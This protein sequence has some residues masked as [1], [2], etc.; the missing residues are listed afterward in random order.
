[1]DRPLG[2]AD[3]ETIDWL[4]LNGGVIDEFRNNGGECGGRF[5][6]NPMILLTTIGAK[7]GL[8]RTS[9]LTY[10]MDGDRIVVIASRA[11]SDRHPDWYINLVAHRDVT[12][13]LGDESFAA[14][15]SIADEPERTRL[16]D[17]RI[18]VMPRFG[19]YLQAT[20]RVIPVVVLER[21]DG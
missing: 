2:N 11:G 14:V 4:G 15:A 10:T 1:M 12:V 21:A 19:E 3:P 7:S 5:E 13:E 9:P 18:A 6:G 16:F 8:E 20:N 17:E